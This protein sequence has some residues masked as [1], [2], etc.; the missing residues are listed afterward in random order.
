MANRALVFPAADAVSHAQILFSRVAEP[1]S[2]FHKMRELRRAI[3]EFGDGP[4]PS[5]DFALERLHR[6]LND[7]RAGL[8]F[9]EVP[10]S[11]SG[12]F[13]CE[14][15][16]CRMASR[17]LPGGC[18]RAAPLPLV[19][20]RPFGTPGVLHPDHW[21]PAYLE[22]YLDQPAPSAE[23]EV[24]ADH[25]AAWTAGGLPPRII[26]QLDDEVW[27]ACDAAGVRCLFLNAGCLNTSE[28]GPLPESGD[29]AF[30]GL[31]AEATA[32]QTVLEQLFQR[33]LTAEEAL[34][35]TLSEV[36]VGEF[37][38]QYGWLINAQSQASDA[39]PPRSSPPP[40]PGQR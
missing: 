13:P 34:H 16:S 2:A 24:S 36:P 32:V 35:T 21:D 40:L 15:G 22:W 3:S 19:F 26:P 14:V 31:R 18:L 30:L 10:S 33:L 6:E 9:R 7:P 11:L 27:A 17:L 4:A 28:G 20:G 25:L 1:G 8:F 39:G 29:L 38:N 23:R 37:L 5:G 12:G